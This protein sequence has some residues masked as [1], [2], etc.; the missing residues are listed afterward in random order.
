[1][2]MYVLLWCKVLVV[3]VNKIDLRVWVFM[4]CCYFGCVIGLRMGGLMVV[5]CCEVKKNV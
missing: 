5:K 1:M 4:L 3:G 2:G